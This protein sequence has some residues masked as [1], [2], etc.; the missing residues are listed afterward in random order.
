MLL[1]E[2]LP[3]VCK[4]PRCKADVKY[5]FD[6]LHS[7]IACYPKRYG[8]SPSNHILSRIRMGYQPRAYD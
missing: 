4:I 7:H 2:N 1:D 3:L 8:I 6:F 5:T